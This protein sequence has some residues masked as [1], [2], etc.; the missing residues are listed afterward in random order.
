MK[1]FTFLTL[2]LVF[3]LVILNCGEDPVTPGENNE[4][5][6]YEQEG[7]IGAQGGIVEITD[8]SNKLYGAYV[9]IPEGVLKT[10]TLISI[11]SVLTSYSYNGDT[12]KTFV[13]LGPAGQRFD[14]PIEVGIPYDQITNV[15]SLNV[16]YFDEEDLV[17]IPLPVINIDTENHIA[18]A[19]TNHFTVF[20]CDD[21][22]QVSFDIDLY[23]SNNTVAAHINLRTLLAQIPTRL[24]YYLETGISNIRDCIWYDKTVYAAFKV[25]LL[26]TKSWND[27]ELETKAIVFRVCETHPGNWYRICAKE[28]EGDELWQSCVLED[29]DG[30]EDYYSG[31]PLLVQF[32]NP[33]SPIEASKNYHVEVRLYYIDNDDFIISP[34]LFNPNGYFVSTV[35]KTKQ[36]SNLPSATSIDTDLDNIVDTYDCV[37]GNKPTVTIIDPQ[38]E[39]YIQQQAIL[40]SGTATDVEDGTISESYYSWSSDKED[41]DLGSGNNFTR[42]DLSVNTH[43]ITLTVT[44]SHGNEGKDEVTID[45]TLG[46]APTATITSPED[47]SS[48]IVGES[49]LFAGTGEDPEEGSLSGEDLVWTSDKDGE[50]GTG[51]SFSTD[52]LSINTHSITLTVNDRNGNT[53]SDNITIHVATDSPPEAT[54]TSPSDGSSFQ[55]GESITFT[56][57]G[58]DDEDGAIPGSSL[59]WT[60]N[61]N[62][63]L[64]TGNSLTTDI[65]QIDTHTI[66]LTAIDSYGNEGHADITIHVISDNPPEATITSPADGSSFQVGES[67]T[68]TGTGTDIEDGTLTGSD[69]VWTSNHDGQLGTGNSIARSDLSENAHTI[70]LTATDS[71]G[72]TDTDNVTVNVNQTEDII[73]P[74]PI[75]DLI[76]SN[77]TTNSI[78]LSW[79]APGD[80][81]NIGTASEY[82]IRYSTAEITEANFG[83]ATECTGEPSPQV[84]GSSE[85]FTVTGLSSNTTYY[86]A[87]KTAD[88]V[89]N[90]SN[91]SNNPSETTTTSSGTVTDID[92]NVYQTVT[93]GTQEWMAENLKVKHYSNG[94]SIPHV[95]DDATWS[96]LTSGAYCNYDNDEGNVATYGRLYNWYAVE[97]SRK[98]APEGW[99][100]PRDEEWQTLV[101]YLGGEAVA[102]GKMKEAGYEHWVDPNTGATNESGFT[103]LP[104]GYR[105][106][107]GTFYGM[108]DYASFWSSTELGSYDAWLRGLG[109]GNARVSRL[110]NYKHYGFSV[111]CVR[112]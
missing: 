46:Q 36:F 14:E 105:D 71:D 78:T 12:L 101:D 28:F 21:H 27:K 95:T 63:H 34:G 76:A 55:V 61:R 97:D 80:D 50:I 51:T 104:G 69:L 1:K 45:V 98:I 100:V 18:I 26:E 86:F 77:P 52:E 22:P 19:Q 111:R 31:D 96:V 93:I 29:I 88:E 35:D 39:E 108:G 58:T 74:S 11:D 32:N 23:N 17:W 99:H 91:I 62:G 10:E 41:G 106:Y 83:S 64:G 85:A 102:G 53:D 13:S 2:L 67:I 73:P 75:M 84:S 92:G 5:V 7:Q 47:E 33:S 9:K 3:S 109:Y 54:I 15:D 107:D 40:F 87:I 43:K 59:Y 68:F 25:T 81:G 72:N 65:L 90:W 37:I 103:A 38:D 110:G 42:D 49:V 20:V 70:T 57:S 30:M 94:D 66:T 56:G 8:E 112:D 79:T 82:D 6:H 16:Y 4:L 24:N 60:S 89:Y 44:D 48:F